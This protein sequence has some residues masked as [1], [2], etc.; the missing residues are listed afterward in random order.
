MYTH[1]LLT[2]RTCRDVYGYFIQRRLFHLYAELND[3]KIRMSNNTHTH[4]LSIKTID[5]FNNNKINTNICGITRST[6]N[7]NNNNNKEK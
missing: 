2:E 4:T 5:K 3:D 7:N 1:I 6:N